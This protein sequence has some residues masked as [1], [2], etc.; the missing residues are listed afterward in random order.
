LPGNPD[1]ALCEAAKKEDGGATT[2]AAA[3]GVGDDDGEVLPNAEEELP[4]T[5]NAELAP[6]LQPP[7]TLGVVLRFANAEASGATGAGAEGVADSEAAGM[8]DPKAETGAGAGDVPKTE[9]DDELAPK[10]N[11]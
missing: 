1:G 6:K 8:E 11:R 5:P 7:K 4:L 10:V 2:A 9:V 3:A